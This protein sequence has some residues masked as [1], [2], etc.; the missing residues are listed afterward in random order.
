MV[1]LCK[2]Y[3]NNSVVA[4]D[5]AGDESLKVENSSEHKKAYEVCLISFL[6][7]MMRKTYIEGTCMKGHAVCYSDCKQLGQLKNS[8]QLLKMFC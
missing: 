8:L 6:K 2:K 5:L 1:E 4:I 7:E 3:Q